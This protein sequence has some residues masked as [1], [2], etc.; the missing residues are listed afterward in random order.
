MI[1]LTLPVPP[2]S[3]ALFRNTT[4]AERSRALARGQKAMKGRAK[5]LAYVSWLNAAGWELK[6]QLR[7]P[8]PQKVPGKVEI[9][10]RM[11]QPSASA[12]CDNRF[13]AAIDLLVLHQVIDD[14]RHVVAA[15]IRWAPVEKCI[16]TVRE[17]VAA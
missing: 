15:S 14:D 8:L 3:N 6:A 12:D 16:V 11:R 7:P 5:T 2:S 1:T 9:E 10:I 4:V 13:K 17:A